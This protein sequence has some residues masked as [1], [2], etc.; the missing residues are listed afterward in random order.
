MVV[1]LGGSW[2]VG[3][4]VVGV[5]MHVQKRGV[6]VGAPACVNPLF[7][8]PRLA[9]KTKVGERRLGVCSPTCGSKG[10]PNRRPWKCTLSTQPKWGLKRGVCKWVTQHEWATF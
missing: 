8:S 3:V 5:W 4:V 6:L 1:S 10:S 9:N 7:G 2:G